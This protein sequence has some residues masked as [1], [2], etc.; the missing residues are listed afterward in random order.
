MSMTRRAFMGLV[1]AIAAGAVAKR[2]EPVSEPLADDGFFVSHN[3]NSRPPLYPLPR[4]VGVEIRQSTGV[5]TGT[6]DLK[7]N[8]IHLDG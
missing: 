8:V 5:K 4:Y 3:T 1:A 6:L 2:R 7:T